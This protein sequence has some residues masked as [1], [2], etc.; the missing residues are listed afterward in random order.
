MAQTGTHSTNDS[1][2]GLP[3]VKIAIGVGVVAGI[4]AAYSFLP[5]NEWIE[6]F[7]Q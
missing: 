5:I 3:W 6:S 2:G 1:G 7:R 4:V